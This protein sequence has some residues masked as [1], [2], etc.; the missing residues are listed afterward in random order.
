M[1]KLITSLTISLM[2]LVFQ[3]QTFVYAQECGSRLTTSGGIIESPDYDNEGLGEHV[4]CTWFI[5]AEEGQ[6]VRLVFTELWVDGAVDGQCDTARIQL[7]DGPDIDAPSLG[8]VLCSESSAQEVTSH[9]RFLTVYFKAGDWDFYQFK[10][11]YSFYDAEDNDKYCVQNMCN[12]TITDQPSCNI[13]SPSYPHG[14]DANLDCKW[15]IQ[16]TKKRNRISLVFDDLKLKYDKRRGKCDGHHVTVYDG[17]DTSK[18]LHGPICHYELDNMEGITIQSTGNKMLIVMT[19]DEE[20]GRQN[21]DDEI[22]YRGFSAQ[23]TMK[24]RF[25]TNRTKPPKTTPTTTTT[26]PVTTTTLATT[27]TATTTKKKKGKKN[28][29]HQKTV[30]TTTI[31]AK[32]ASPEASTVQILLNVPE[33]TTTSISSAAKLTSVVQSTN[34][35]E[36]TESETV[37]FNQAGPSGFLEYGHYVIAAVV[38]SCVIAL[39]CFAIYRMRKRRYSGH[40]LVPTEKI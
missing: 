27:T 17:H 1:L 22:H 39:T 36:T 30:T 8:T 15:Y 29:K 7:H 31:P 37:E 20:N 21:D 13:Q 16:S 11:E 9:T 35:K 5:E 33:S 19:S 14:Y 6:R 10:I 23:I 26:T 34:S 18:K 3:C 38:G 32:T 40:D 24:T 25:K 2:L 4:E 12:A 28:R